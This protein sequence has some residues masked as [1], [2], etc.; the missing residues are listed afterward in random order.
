A[1][2]FPELTIIAG[3][4][5]GKDSRIA[6]PTLVREAAF[7]GHE[8]SL[9]RGERATF[10]CVAQDRSGTAVAFGYT[11]TYFTESPLLSKL[12]DEV[13]TNELRLTTG[14]RVQTYPCTLRSLRAV[15]IPCAILDEVAFYR[16]EGSADSD[17]EIQTSVR[18]GMLGFPQA[19]LMKI[20]T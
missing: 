5:A 15:S 16:L 11:A 14:A 7:G 10:A 9:G 13:L 4:R 12:V 2:R 3:A 8:S 6:C 19:R 18:R 17:Q 20:S 1:R